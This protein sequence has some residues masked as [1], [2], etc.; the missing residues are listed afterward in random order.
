MLQTLVNRLH[1]V[2]LTAA[3]AALVVAGCT[4]LVDSSEGGATPE[5]AAAKKA[6]LEKAQP[7]M[8]EFCVS[9]HDGSQANI[10]FLEGADPLA[11]RDDLV[12]FE[13]V[14]VNFGAPQS[15]RLLTKGV[16]SG[17]ALTSVQASDLLDWVQK[18]QAARGS[19]GG[20]ETVLK[21]DAFLP[22]ICTAG[23]PGTAECPFNTVALDAI[24]SPGSTIQFTVQSLG[25]G[26]YVSNLKLIPGPMGAYVEHPLFVSLPEGAEPKPDT[27]DRF[28]SVKMNLEATAPE[29][30]QQIAGGTAAFVGFLATDKLEIHFKKLGMFEMGDG[31][32]GGGGGT[33][34]CKKLTEFKAVRELFTTNVG[35]AANNCNACHAGQVAGATGALNITGIG[36]A[37]DTVVQAACNQILIRVNLTTPD[38]SGIF[39][40]PDP[41][42]THP[43]RFNAAQLNTFKNGPPA[44]GLLGWINA[45]KTAP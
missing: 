18:E 45:E 10:G 44:T 4:G 35:G 36:S 25:S 6:W 17:P 43:F 42:S 33:S 15:S 32:G 39:L 3:A 2:R 31:G 13:P 7:V 22:L 34:G 19:V 30:Q 1:M 9:C 5:E 29:D 8:Q 24:G 41:G 21:T 11:M 26:L 37:D 16:H 38:Q 14:V 20:G 27:I 40:A 12:A 28:F 23:S